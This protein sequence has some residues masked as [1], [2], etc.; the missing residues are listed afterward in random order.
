MPENRTRQLVESALQA[1]WKP[2]GENV[3]DEVLEII[4]ND[5][6]LLDE[7]CEIADGFSDGTSGLNR[8]IGYFVKRITGR[9]ALPVQYPCKRNGLARTYSK[10]VEP[11]G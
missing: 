7:Y 6:K 10:L 5:K 8:N 1:L 4:E 2:Y 3:T 11:P 9:T